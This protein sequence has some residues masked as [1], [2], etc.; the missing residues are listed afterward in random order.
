V[1]DTSLLW[2]AV[3]SGVGTFLVRFLPMAWHMR[4]S[5]RRQPR[6]A[7][8]RGMDAIGPA[9]IVALLTVSLWG[10]VNGAAPMRSMLA[11]AAGLLGVWLGRRYVGSIAWATLA[12][13]LA[14]GAMLAVVPPAF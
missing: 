3:L 10:L 11:V 4:N 9:A 13:V 2:I 8:R 12:G 5:A 6:G 14:Y 7:W 1:S